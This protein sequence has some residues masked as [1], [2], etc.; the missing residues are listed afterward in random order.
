MYPLPFGPEAIPFTKDIFVRDAAYLPFASMENGYAPFRRSSVVDGQ[1]GEFS[2]GTLLRTRPGTGVV[3]WNVNVWAK[4]ALFENG[5]PVPQQASVQG[6]A[7]QVS[8]LKVRVRWPEFP[9]REREILMDIGSGFTISVGPTTQAEVELMVP[10]EQKLTTIV[11]V[12]LQNLRAS[13]Y[14]VASCWAVQA[15]IGRPSGRATQAVYLLADTQLV[16]FVKIADGARFVQIFA[17]TAG[18]GLAFPPSFRAQA[19]LASRPLGR[20]SF[21]A[22]DFN[23]A[24]T[25]IAQ[26]AKFIAFEA[27]PGSDTIL[28]VVQELEL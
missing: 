19:N 23:T 10:D 8:A 27:M 2:T 9:S 17:D 28:N 4:E 25:E 24:K 26:N 3:W 18:G 15:P 16:Q 11:P 1:I 21:P 5:Q 12:G 22:L 6:N 14:V 7:I 20:I 13:T